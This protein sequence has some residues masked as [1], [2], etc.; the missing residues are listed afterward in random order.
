MTAA[1]GTLGALIF[2][3]S[4]GYAIGTADGITGISGAAVN[5]TA[6]TLSGPGLINAPVVN[7]TTANGMSVLVGG[8][9]AGLS[10]SN[11][12]S[13]DIVLTGGGST[14]AVTS[15]VNFSVGGTGASFSNAAVGG[16]YY[17]S[18]LNNMQLNAGTANDRYAR[19]AAGGTLTSS[20][21]SNTS[22]AGVLMLANG[23]TF[24]GSSA[25]IAG[26]LG[27]VSGGAINVNSNV[28]ASSI[29]VVGASLNVV[30]ATFDS[31]A[32][33]FV[34]YTTGNVVV[35][36]GGRIK[37]NP[38]VVL[39]VGGNILLDSGGKIEAVSPNSVRV[40]FPSA[41][42]GGYI[43]N[44]VP[45][46]VADPATGTGFYAAGLPASVG[47]GFV[48]S[49]GIAPEVVA[50][51]AATAAA[52]TSVAAAI[53]T[54]VN[55]TNTTTTTNTTSTSV[56][57][58]FGGGNP[59]PNV[60][61]ANTTVAANSTP[62]DGG[63]PSSSGPAGSGSTSNT[64]STAESGPTDSASGGNAGASGNAGSKTAASSDKDKD[65]DKDG[66]KDKKKTSEKSSA[67]TNSSRTKVALQCN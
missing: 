48:T 57:S 15:P 58:D 32:A 16:G 29:D 30:G 54:V 65:K 21:Y 55:A 11:T 51:T 22:S 63:A 43:V 5:L 53:S 25:N 10:A 23:A 52:T 37:G 19:F 13:G 24:N 45:G 26:A 3:S 47:S 1:T 67:S 7:L 56:M 14:S 28:S 20:G 34:G 31:T 18:A 66:E 35:N 59:S 40:T 6:D 9:G 61:S 44:G 33:N 49:Y 27:I 50:P 2:G 36:T 60:T 38:D 17:I 8:N 46:L 41:S 4:S 39:T 12:T 62:T 42:G 64:S